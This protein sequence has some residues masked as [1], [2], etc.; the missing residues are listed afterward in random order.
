MFYTKATVLAAFIFIYSLAHSQSDFPPFGDFNAEEMSIKQCAFDP[1]AEAIILLD[2]AIANYDDD[3]H[4][5]IE[6]RIRIKILT[7]KGIDRAN[8]VIPFYHKDEFE[9]ITKVEAYTYNWD[10]SKNASFQ[11]VEKK[12]IY[13]EKQNNYYSLIKFA[14]PSVKA[15]SI[16]E[17]HYVST[18]KHY[19]GLDEWKFQSDLPTMKSSF[20]VNILPRAEFA[21]TV[22]KK[23]T[24][25]IFI[26]PMPDQGR[27]YFEMNNVPAL[28]IEPYMDAKRDYIQKVIFQL[29]GYVSSFGTKQQVNTTWKNLAYEMMTEKDFGS[30]LDKDLK[31]DEVKAIALLENTQQ[32]KVK[33]IYDYVRKNIAWNGYDGKYAIDG[34][35]TV[36]DRKKGS[37]GEINLLLVNLLKTAGIETYPVL[38]AERD[39]GKVDTTYPFIDRFNKTIAFAIADGKQY[40]LDAT[41]ENC[42]AGLTPYSLLNTTGFLVDKKSF[43]LI[44]IGTGNKAYRNVITVNATMDAKGSVTGEAQVRSLEYARQMR[45]TSVKN[46]RSRF[47]N[48]NFEKPYEGLTIDSFMVT[49]PEH[50]SIPFEQII[51]YKQQPNESGGLIFYNSNLFTGLEK[52]P[53]LSSVRFT[54][55]NFG[56]PY[57]VMLEETVKLPAGAK[58]DV[59]EAKSLSFD[60][61]KIFATRAVKFENGELK[62]SIRFIQNLTLI[63]A[64][65]YAGMKDFYKKMVDMLNEPIVMKLGN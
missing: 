60:N 51:R 63:K 9:Y 53:F 32:G 50:D 16:I 23:N 44:K 21:Y 26:K 35:K 13:T 57:N 2:K 37:A 24:L 29:A 14:M 48:E 64:E 8:I 25:N 30:Q 19:G 61:N 28:R 15:G 11:A 47:V 56:Y 42:P 18:M 52:N 55:V 10:A 33:A 5:I 39:F 27:I 12:S 31:I 17:Y 38:A 7:D 43:N 40:L 4:L 65:D 59:P 58:I 62:V 45:L 1:E 3:Y 20:L 41:Q 36:W 6:R 22:Q 54:N 34:L 46:N 49:I